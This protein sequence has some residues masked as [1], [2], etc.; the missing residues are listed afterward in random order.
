MEF[1]SVRS[2]RE[3]KRVVR[4]LLA[5]RGRWTHGERGRM[6]LLIRQDRHREKV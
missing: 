5:G 3:R 4:P 6:R 1:Y 2:C